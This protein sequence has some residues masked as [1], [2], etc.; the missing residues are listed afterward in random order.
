MSSWG[1]W[2]ASGA[3]TDQGGKDRRRD[4]FEEEDEINFQHLH[5]WYQQETPVDD[6]NR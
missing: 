2:E 4:N 5:L 1:K 3:A 6:P